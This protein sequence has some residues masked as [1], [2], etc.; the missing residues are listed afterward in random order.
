MTA[1]TEGAG[2]PG[3]GLAVTTGDRPGREGA[4]GPG[5]KGPSPGPGKGPPK[6]G[7]GG[8]GPS[9][10][11]GPNRSSWHPRWRGAAAAKPSVRTRQD[12]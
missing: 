2:V 7:P 4:P 10:S 1:G 12:N 8:K 11:P 6:S 9:I 5:G 3:S